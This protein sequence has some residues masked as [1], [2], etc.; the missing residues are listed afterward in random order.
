MAYWVSGSVIPFDDTLAVKST[1]G[2]NTVTTGGIDTRPID[3]YR[4]GVELNTIDKFFKSTQPKLW[5]GSIKFDGTVSH[6]NETHTYGQT[7]SF[8]QFY[9]KS[10]YDDRL[11]P[12]DPVLYIKLGGSFPTPILFNDGPQQKEENVV[13]PLTIA[14]KRSTNEAVNY[15][16]HAMHGSI[17][18]GQEDKFERGTALLSQFVDKAVPTSPKPFLDSGEVRMGDNFS[19]SIVVP[20]YISTVTTKIV[21]FSDEEFAT[22]NLT[23]P[24]HQIASKLKGYMISDGFI[25]A[26][27][28]SAT[29]GVDGYGPKQAIYG[30]DSYAFRNRLRGS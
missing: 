9:G 11:I 22:G 30:T 3:G 2:I 26:K 15:I 20:G 16:A 12:F 7:V 13:E 25:P 6:L 4:Q 21:P 14:F 5:G 24:L 17:E 1:L 10:Q 28:R 8:A 29:A 19:G 18:D 27:Q 23:D